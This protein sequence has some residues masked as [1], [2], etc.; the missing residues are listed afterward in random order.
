MKYKP[1]DIVVGAFVLAGVVVILVG[2]FLIRGI[3]FV[4]TSTVNNRST[5]HAFSICT[6]ALEK[7]HL[8]A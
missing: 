6:A 5:P 3:G 1:L 4:S 7:P 2:M 8:A